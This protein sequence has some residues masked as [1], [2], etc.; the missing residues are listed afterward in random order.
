[1]TRVLVIAV[2][3]AFFAVPMAGVHQVLRHPLVTRVPLA[4]PGLLGVVNVRGEIVPLLD[5]GVLTGTGGLTE[6]PFAVLV[7]GDKEMVALA[8]EE[9]PI[10]TDFEAPVGP[11][12][13]PGELGVYSNGGRLVVLVDIEEL[14]KNRLDLKRAS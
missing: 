10:A 14:V 3:A 2:N 5:T 8:A 12:T 6:P 13:Y 9:L 4:P 11:G 7:S 1:M